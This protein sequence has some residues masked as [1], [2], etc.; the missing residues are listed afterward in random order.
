MDKLHEFILIACIIGLAIYSMK[1]SQDHV[2]SIERMNHQ[3]QMMF[4]K[5]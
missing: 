2:A 1:I 5:S 3:I 4:V